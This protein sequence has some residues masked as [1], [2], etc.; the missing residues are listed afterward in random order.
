MI[1]IIFCSELG[2]REF[3]YYLLYYF[4]DLPKQ[5]LNHKFNAFPW[6]QDQDLLRCWQIGQTAIPIVDVGM[7]ELWQMGYIHNLVR[8]I[9]GSFLVKN[10]LSHIK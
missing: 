5:N 8:M 2:W 10:L 6:S 1:L 9:V 3:S 4:P 7:R